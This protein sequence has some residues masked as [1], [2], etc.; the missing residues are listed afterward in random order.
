MDKIRNKNQRPPLDAQ[1]DMIMGGYSPERLVKEGWAP[2]DTSEVSDVHDEREWG[3][4]A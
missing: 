3:W 2:P 4:I 1:Y